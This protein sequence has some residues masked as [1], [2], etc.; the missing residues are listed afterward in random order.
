MREVGERWGRGGGEDVPGGGCDME[1]AALC[2]V[3]PC[4][5][6]TTDQ[7]DALFFAQKTP[8]L[9]LLLLL[10]CM[11]LLCMLLC[12]LERGRSV[13]MYYNTHVIRLGL[14]HAL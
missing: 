14:E 3:Y 6:D 7:S 8:P 5:Y 4:G 2:P 11:L 9:L 10:L 12:L 1:G 13:F